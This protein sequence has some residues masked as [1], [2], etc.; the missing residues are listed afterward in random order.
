[1]MPAPKHPLVAKHPAN[2][3]ALDRLAEKRAKVAPTSNYTY[4]LKRAMESLKKCKEPI[5]TNKDALALPGVGPALAQIIAPLEVLRPA[6]VDSTTTARSKPKRKRPPTPVVDA[7]P[8]KT[9]S[10]K[11]AAYVQ[12]QEHALDY[13]TLPCAMEW[14]VLL[15]IDGREQKSDHMQAKCQMSGIPTEERHVSR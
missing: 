15:L 13:K 10:A 4:T 9:V 3:A 5:V 8:P 12:A 14:K 1:M 2:Q 7:P 11:E 6:G